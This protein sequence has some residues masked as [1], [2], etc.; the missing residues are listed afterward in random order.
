MGIARE[1]RERLEVVEM[2][3][4]VEKSLIF[5]RFGVVGIQVVREW[6]GFRVRKEKRS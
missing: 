1:R 2:R 3:R 4:V 5:L 6:K